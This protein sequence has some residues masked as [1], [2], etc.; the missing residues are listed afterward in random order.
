VDH[1]DHVDP[2]SGKMF[3]YHVWENYKSA[4]LAWYNLGAEIEVLAIAGGADG[5]DSSYTDDGIGGSGGE[6]VNVKGMP[7]SPDYQIFSII[8]G[9]AGNPTIVRTPGMQKELLPGAMDEPLVLDDG[10]KAVLGVDTIGGKGSDAVGP[11]DA[12]NFGAGGSGGFKLKEPYAQ[13]SYTT[14]ESSGGPYTYDCSYGARGETYQS[15]STPVTGDQRPCNGCPGHAHICH[16]PCE[17][18]FA[19][20]HSGGESWASRG[21]TGCPGGWHECGCNCCTSSPTYAT[22]Y[23]CDSGGS[24]SGTTCVRSCSGNDYKEWTETHWTPCVSGMS[25]VSRTCTDDRPT[26][27]GKGKGGIVAIRYEFNPD[28]RLA[29]VTGTGVPIMY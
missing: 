19:W 20:Y 3:R 9:D 10:W 28:T 29:P 2:T 4:Q 12:T 24:L 13:Q 6:W 14:T 21:Q 17:C 8:P 18:N 27:G 5:D 23:H 15:G 11:I 7:V 1:V 25:P 22:R 26:G 16:G